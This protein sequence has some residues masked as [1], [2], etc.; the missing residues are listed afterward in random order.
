MKDKIVVG[1]DCRELTRKNIGSLG[2][3]LLYLLSDLKEYRL[4]LLS[5]VELKA[6]YIPSNAVAINRGMECTGGGD[7]VKYQM[8][9]KKKLRENKADVMFQIN[10]YA[11]IPIKGIKQITVVHDLYP[12]EGFEKTSVL[13]KLMYRLSLAATMINSDIIFTVSEFSKNRL[14]KFFWKSKK[15][16]VN[17]NGIDE[18][19]KEIGA[20]PVE[21]GYFLMLGRVCYWKRTIEFA[22]LFS[23]YL[24]PKGYRLVIAGMCDSEEI[25]SRMRQITDTDENVDWLNYVS[26]EVREALMQNA[27]M[28]VYPTRYDGFGLPPLELAKRKIPVIMSDIPVLREVTQNKGV[29]IDFDEDDAKIANEVINA[30]ENYSDDVIEAMYNVAQSYTWKSNISKVKECINELCKR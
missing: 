29:Y 3:I 9:M 22:E 16:R 10:H 8:W 17:Y 21:K 28:F 11:L 7:L 4:I 25:A 5:D 6:E 18:P 19:Q 1:V 2:F 23:K 24:S 15:I 27:A 20:L 12:I 14:E 13:Y 26:N 30:Y